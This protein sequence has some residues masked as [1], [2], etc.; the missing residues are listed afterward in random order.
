MRRL[1][2]RCGMGFSGHFDYPAPTTCSPSYVGSTLG[3]D[4][5]RFLVDGER[6]NGS[7]IPGSK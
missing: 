2:Y 6:Y 4:L 3:P 7:S 5:S 1:G